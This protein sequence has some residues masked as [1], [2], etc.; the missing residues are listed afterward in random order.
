LTRHTV[1]ALR[2]WLAEHGDQGHPDDPLF[3]SRSGRPLSPDAVERLVAKH[4]TTA[5]ATCTSIQAKNVTPHTLR[6]SA[7]MAL[8]HSGVDISVIALWLGHESLE[9]SMIYLHADMT[10][11]ERALARTTP[12]NSTPGRYKAP[13]TVLAF[14]DSL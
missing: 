9:T 1:N 3:A 12:P 7:A 2:A 11:K 8:L 13:D 4:A 6:H 5:A 10:L 14:L